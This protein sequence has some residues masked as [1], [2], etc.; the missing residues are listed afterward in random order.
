MGR[1]YLVLLVFVIVAGCAHQ[2]DLI[3]VDKVDIQGNQAVSESAITSGLATRAL[4][5]W[6]FSDK[7]AFDEVVFAQDITR[8][9]T[10]YKTIGYF[11]ARVVSQEVSPAKDDR[12][13]VTVVVEEGEPSLVTSVRVVP[14]DTTPDIAKAAAALVNLA[15]R[16][17]NQERYLL[18]KADYLKALRESGYCEAQV[19]GRVLV[20]SD[21]VEMEVLGEPG[22]LC[23]IRRVILKG[24]VDLGGPIILRHSHLK[25]GLL[26]TPTTLRR[27]ERGVYAL[28]LFSMVRLEISKET[29]E[30]GEGSRDKT[31]ILPLPEVPLPED[32]AHPRMVNLTMYV[33]KKPLRELKAGVGVGF[34]RAMQQVRA[35]GGWS[36]RNFFG[37]L[38]S[39]SLEG[40]AGYTFMPTFWEPNN[41]GPTGELSAS[42]VQP[43]FLEPS[44]TLHSKLSWELGFEEAFQFHSPK[45]RTGL[46]RTM[47][48]DVKVEAW[49]EASYYDFF[50]IR[51]AIHSDVNN[52]LGDDF[53]DPFILTTLGQ[54]IEWDGRDDPLATRKGVYARVTMSESFYKL[55][56][57]FQFLKAEGDLRG[58]VSPWSWL[59]LAGRVM[60]GWA[61]GLG[62]GG[63][64]PITA[65]FIAGGANSV[66]GFDYQRLSPYAEKCYSDGRC[67]R[68][69]VG[70]LSLAVASLETRFHLGWNLSTALFA[71]VGTV[72]QTELGIDWSQ[73]AWNT[74]F[75]FR[76]LT[77]VGP[78][79][80]DFAFRL[81]DPEAYSHLQW[82]TFYLTLGEAF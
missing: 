29:E 30:S 28:G 47:A 4:S 9:E 65:R 11:K 15:E 63:S 26:V 75:G 46:E 23:F 13:R 2:E 33:Q 34:D 22:P 72:D 74:G 32:V 24:D 42:L 61:W 44:L 18:A 59:T 38:R 40:V 39:F 16:P 66:R 68:V 43:G 12:V 69:P 81:N 31:R 36:H 58:Y 50:N 54:A 62:A 8:I 3:Y 19:K 14:D 70:G 17:F 55:G 80:L 21:H 57:D 49:F 78:F 79:R 1:N 53:R 64:V 41:S 60:N 27:S 35:V 52:P 56:S 67:D 25:Q 48:W 7:I 51:G 71:D 5:W 77:P 76:Y 37:G 10:F 6:P 82:W 45:L 20:K 73:L